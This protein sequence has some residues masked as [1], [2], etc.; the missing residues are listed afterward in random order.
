MKTA[1]FAARI[2]SILL[3]QS[4]SLHGQQAPGSPE[5]TGC[6]LVV[7]RRWE[8]RSKPG[9]SVLAS[10]GRLA[11]RGDTILIASEF[12]WRWNL[13]PDTVRSADG[14]SP[15]AGAIELSP[16]GRARL[17]IPPPGF[18]AFHWLHPLPA[19]GGGW[20]ILAVELDSGVTNREDARGWLVAAHWRAGQ[21]SRVR[22]L[23][24][25][26][27]AH[28]RPE[29]GGNP[30]RVGGDFVAAYGFGR[31]MQPGGVV[32]LRGSADGSWRADTSLLRFGVVTTRVVPTRTGTDATLYYVAS[33]ISPEGN[34]GSF[35]LFREGAA[36]EPAA[37]QLVRPADFGQ[38]IRP[39][40]AYA[41][42]RTAIAWWTPAT[43]RG[44]VPRVLAMSIPDQGEPDGPAVIASGSN[45][46]TMG[47]LA[48]HPM[49]V[50]R[51][52]LRGDRLRLLHFDD[53][54]FVELPP[55]ELPNHT[56]FGAIALGKSAM[57]LITSRLPTKASASASPATMVSE[58]GM[59]CPKSP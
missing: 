47:T 7:R 58:L 59:Q 46:I 48:G 49:V 9:Q 13:S 15:A 40:V 6:S 16:S 18:A 39:E 41:R 2:I 31:R 21:W 57:A 52:S 42:G 23:H 19:K 38:V 51:D 3:L 17:L 37:R 50:M 33:E 8:A 44:E 26:S 30:V 4:T 10:P 55:L 43:R 34:P 36:R 35:T 5:P 24:R 20:D 25:V 32:I 14:D 56:A 11:V 53:R 28:L 54:R 45:E 27:D 12:V 29:E 1:P 22:R